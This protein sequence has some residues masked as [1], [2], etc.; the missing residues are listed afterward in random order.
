MSDELS[1]SKLVTAPPPSDTHDL[2][3]LRLDT[4]LS[5]PEHTA[6]SGPFDPPALDVG[7]LSPCPNVRGLADEDAAEA[8]VEWFWENFEDPVHHTPHDEGEYV[9]IWGGPYDAR[10]ELE[11][12][13]SSTTS[14]RAI[15]IATD[16]IETEG[17]E[18][19]PSS[20]RIVPETELPARE[21]RND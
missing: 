21:D 17:F 3:D 4:T 1:K 13:F 8:M 15:E 20:A 16:S 12:A 6:G 11:A 9:F 10:E 14:E 5:D 2:F 7:P 18:W 19:V